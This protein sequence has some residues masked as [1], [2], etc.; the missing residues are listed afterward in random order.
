MTTEGADVTATTATV[1]GEV[2][3]DV[4]NGGAP[5]TPGLQYGTDPANLSNQRRARDRPRST[6]RLQATFSS[7]LTTGT[8]YFYRVTAANESN[9]VSS[10]RAGIKE[11]QPAGP[12][13]ITEEFG[14]LRQHGWCEHLGENHSGWWTDR[15]PIEFGRPTRLWRQ[16]ACNAEQT[17]DNL[18]PENVT[19][20]DFGADCRHALPL[21]FVAENPERRNRRRRSHFTTFAS[22][23]IGPDSAQTRRSASR[24]ARPSCWTAVPTSSPRPGTRT[25]TTSA[26][27][28]F[29]GRTPSVQQPG[30]GDHLLYS[31][32]FGTVPGSGDP[33]NFGLDPYVATRNR[34]RTVGTRTTSAS[35]PAGL[36]RRLRSARRWPVRAGAERVCFRQRNPL[37]SVLLGRVDRDP[38]PSAER[39]PRSRAEG[40]DPQNQRGTRGIHRPVAVR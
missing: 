39:H 11:L 4:P 40:L 22:P 14:F 27:R 6:A 34:R 16:T 35:R 29:P 30:A 13:E 28:S 19:L 25:A 8:T 18:A 38:R 12:P 2:D 3:R 20:R 9:Q 5:I 10:H 21:R 1:Q 26:R 36:P 23:A 37:R 17:E 7:G 31:L 33:T 15:M 32:Q 24:R